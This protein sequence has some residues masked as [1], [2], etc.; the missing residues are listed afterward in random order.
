MRRP[1]VLFSILVVISI[2]VAGPVYA[3][4]PAAEPISKE[5][6]LPLVGKPDVT[7]IDLRFG[8]DWYDSNSKIKGAI[9]EDPMK[10]GQWMDKYPK[11][12]MLVLYCD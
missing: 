8:R 3:A 12:R 5:Q 2:I 10:P 4:P 1:A 6:L 9:R 11:D 7:V